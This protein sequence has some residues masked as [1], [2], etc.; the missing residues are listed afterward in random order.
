MT[1]TGFP[2]KLLLV[3]IGLVS[4]CISGYEYELPLRTLLIGTS[5]ITLQLPK[6]VIQS[7]GSNYD[8]VDLDQ[9][10]ES[11]IKLYDGNG[12]PKYNSIVFTDDDLGAVGENNN[13][14]SL[15]SKDVWKKIYDY[16]K[17]YN[18][19]SVILES[20]PNSDKRIKS[21]SGYESGTNK[22]AVLSFIQ[23]S[24]FVD[25]FRSNVKKTATFHFGKVDDF[26]TLHAWYYPCVIDSKSSNNKS[27]IEPF[28]TIDLKDS[29]GKIHKKNWLGAF[30]RKIDGREEI[31]FMVNVGQYGH[32]GFL[33]GDMWYPWLQRGIFLGQRRLL[34]D[35][36]IDDIFLKTFFVQ[37]NRKPNRQ[38]Q[39]RIS[40]QW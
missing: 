22:S 6:L 2:V 16:Q 7:Y 30:L 24:H 39:N 18:V 37:R 40:C 36:Q 27:I 5:K 9:D 28:M 31:H 38:W 10:L 15:L 13:F 17:K 34:L 33:L 25:K 3:L 1:F 20:S 11:S 29:D 8:M 19:R 12:N 23:N 21:V 14:Y 26:V 35:T 4:S 32:H